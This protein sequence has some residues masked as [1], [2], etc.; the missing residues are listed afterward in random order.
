MWY[1]YGMKRA[2]CFI[3]I[4][5]FV[6]A[7]V[8][9]CACGRAP[10][11]Y[12]GD[13]VDLYTEAINSILNAKG[14]VKR[15]HGGY[16]D[17][18]ITILAEDVYGRIFFEYTEGSDYFLLISQKTADESIY[19]YPD[20]NFLIVDREDLYYNVI[21]ADDGT[22]DWGQAWWESDYLVDKVEELKVANDWGQEIK[23]EKCIKYPIA[24]KK[25]DPLGKREGNKL[26]KDIYGEYESDGYGYIRY[27]TK[28]DEGKELYLAVDRANIKHDYRIVIVDGDLHC[29]VKIENIKEYQEQLAM[30]KKTMGWKKS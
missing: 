8:T 20:F 24:Y 10:Y 26:Y 29:N 16:N 9:L 25:D 30:T 23:I 2:F 3:L 21:L 1:A 22:A 11:S 14:S 6:L 28:D 15:I 4:F 17:P 27:V 5:I 7:S 12:S 18:W 19:Y 13:Y